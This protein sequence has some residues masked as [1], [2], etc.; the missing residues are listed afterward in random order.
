MVDQHV[1]HPEKEHYK[2]VGEP[3]TA[4]RRLHMLCSA[5]SW[6]KQ[7]KSLKS[8]ADAIDPSAENVD[9]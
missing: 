3:I 6:Y 1:L 4:G 7:M 5:V 9:L 8:A 2:T